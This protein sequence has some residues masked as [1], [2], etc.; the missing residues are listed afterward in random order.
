MVLSEHKARVRHLAE[1]FSTVLRGREPDD[2]AQAIGASLEYGDL[3]FNDGAFDPE[4][5][6]V[7]L[8]RAS[9]RSRQRF[10][11]AHEV[12]HALILEDDDL[13]SDL[14]DAYEG[15]ELETAI[16]VLCNV[17]AAAMLAPRQELEQLL[18]RTGRRAISIPRISQAFGLSR[19]AACVAFTDVLEG[20]AIVA[21]L[22][23]RGRRQRR[24][25]EV[26]FA[27]KTDEMRYTL[28]PGITMPEDHPTT[29]ALE[30]DLPVCEQAF[31]PF[32]SGRRMPALVDAH[33]EGG[34]VYT[35][36]SIAETTSKEPQ[37]IS[38]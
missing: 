34:Y 19:P 20:R 13:L 27:T 11:A 29:L 4:R 7:L 25:L 2:L 35:V 9:G 17:G 30:T 36:F 8:N 33:P 6:V 37:T 18:E 3:S 1:R 38:N 14:H 16:E 5:R 10:T 22:R 24:H 21:V 23:P 32:R 12:T 26:E 31:I 15:E 28:S